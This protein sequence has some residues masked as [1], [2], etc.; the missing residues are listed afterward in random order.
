MIKDLLGYKSRKE[1]NKGFFGVLKA[2]FYSVEE[3]AR[4]NL[5]AHFLL[6][7]DKPPFDLNVLETSD[8]QRKYKQECNALINYVDCVQS[9]RLIGTDL[10]QIIHECKNRKNV[11]LKPTIKSNQLL[12]YIRHQKGCRKYRAAIFDCRRCDKEW[13]AD[14]IAIEHVYNSFARAY[15]SLRSVQLET[16][17]NTSIADS[18]IKKQNLLK[19]LIYR[20]KEYN[21]DDTF[22]VSLAVNGC[23]NCHSSY[24]VR[25]CFRNGKTECHYKFPK[26][27][28]KRKTKVVFQQ[29][30]NTWFDVTGRPKKKRIIEVVP[31][32]EEYD[33][34]MNSYCPA[35][36]NSNLACN[37]NVKVIANGIQAFYITKYSSKKT[38]KDDGSEYVPVANYIERRLIFRKFQNDNSETLSRIIGA[39]MANNKENIISATLANYLIHNGSRFNSVP[40]VSYLPLR[41]MKKILKQKEVD[42]VV[43]TNFIGREKE[44]QENQEKFCYL[45]LNCWHYLYRPIELEDICMYEFFTEF[46]VKSFYGKKNDN[47]VEDDDDD[48]DV[49]LCKKSFK[50]IPPHPGRSVQ[51]V[52]RRKYKVVAGIDNWEIPDASKLNGDIMDENTVSSPIIED[53][54]LNCLCLFYPFRCEKDLTIDGSYMKLF[55][56]EFYTFI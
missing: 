14:D 28:N 8:N 30:D 37:S 7:L 3:Q 4:K 42:I 11:N 54:C 46:Y 52:K 25:T 18:R 22:D 16:T 35:V 34:M 48:D 53:Y 33:I 19:E 55:R 27:P 36:S 17:T 26:L 12:R 13:S 41:L 56:E 32:R 40:A 15:P 43:R 23:L 45:E 9:N 6:W 49:E 47:E 38:Q 39:S 2:F 31:E 1:V 24:H 51:R 21:K 20:V 10:P 29:E 44:N 50:S 5:H